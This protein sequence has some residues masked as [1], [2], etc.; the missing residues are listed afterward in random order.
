MRK[1]FSEISSKKRI[2]PSKRPRRLPYGIEGLF[3][4]KNEKDSASAG[5]SGATEGSVSGAQE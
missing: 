3:G 5:N 4:R 2:A 1:D